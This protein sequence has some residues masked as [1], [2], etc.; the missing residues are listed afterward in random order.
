MIDHQGHCGRDGIGGGN[1][2]AD[3]SA[4]EGGVIGGARSHAVYQHGLAHARLADDDDGVTL[5]RGEELVELTKLVQAAD[6]RAT[7]QV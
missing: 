6:E 5:G 7:I 2:V 3:E 4:F 1:F